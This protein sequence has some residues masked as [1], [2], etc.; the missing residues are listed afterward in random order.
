MGAAR[1]GLPPSPQP[2]PESQIGL[3]VVC[4]WE[5]VCELRRLRDELMLA[6]ALLKR[7]V[8]ESGDQL[9]AHELHE[10]M[11]RID[12]IISR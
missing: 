6:L 1:W 7:F 3:T 4:Y 12:E 8:E 5:A 9:K 10:A 11:A 2:K